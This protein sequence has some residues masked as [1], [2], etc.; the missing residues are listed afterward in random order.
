[1]AA[2][3]TS[4]SVRHA[5]LFFALG[6]IAALA[7]SNVVRSLWKGGPWT[8]LRSQQTGDVLPSYSGRSPRRL[9]PR[10][11]DR[12]QLPKKCGLVFFYHVPSTGGATINTWLRQYADKET[13]PYFTLWGRD[14]EM[15]A[16]SL[17]VNE[18]MEEAFING[19]PRHTGMNNFAQNIGPE[20]WRIAHCHHSSMHLN[21]TEEY[22]SQWRDSV[23]SQGCAFVAAV[24][25]REPLSHSMSLYKHIER[26][27]SSR[28][29][30][31]EHLQTL[32]ET[33]FW[34]T[35]LDYFLYN[36]IT[37]NPSGVDKDAKV[38]R[39]LE[40]L[41]KHFDIVTVGEH[42]RFKRELLEW[43]GWA[44]KEMRQTNTHT[45]EILF[46]KKEVEALQKQMEENG[47]VEFIYEVKKLFGGR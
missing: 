11:V 40:I 44:D 30:W 46:S 15:K 4:P 5:L 41:T 25:F 13:T 27:N 17:G 23:E 33:G 47:D 45:K 39:A 31:T 7:L 36:F 16:N 3:K 24:M 9:Q 32:S 1:M 6:Q 35:Q 2:A 10:K 26:F 12:T 20:E 37:R 19:N 8:Y 18:G 22:L 28:A 38:Q 34:Q 29:V 43:T 42:D 14:K 21:A